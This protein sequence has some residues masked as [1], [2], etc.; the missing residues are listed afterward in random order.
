MLLMF[1]V[2]T[3]FFSHDFSRVYILKQN[4]KYLAQTNAA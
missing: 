1:R 4:V 3:K 2:G